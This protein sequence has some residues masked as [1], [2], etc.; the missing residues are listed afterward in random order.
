MN[1]I[2][3]FNE[4]TAQ[5][6]EFKAKY[7]DVVYNMEIPKE[8]KQARSDQR[9]IGSIVQ[10]LKKVKKT[11]KAPILAQMTNIDTTSKLLEEN[12]RIVQAKI[13]TQ[14]T[15]HDTRI[16][17]HKAMLQK[18]LD[19]ITSYANTALHINTSDDLF[20]LATKLA[21]TIID[22]SYEY[23]EE[24]AKTA[25]TAILND[26][27]KKHTELL[28]AEKLAEEVAVLRAKE[29]ERAKAAHEAAIAK[30]AAQQATA[31][32]E[33]LAQ[34]KLD[35]AAK[36]AENIRLANEQA[37]VTARLEKEAIENKLALAKIAAKED[38]DK[39]VAAEVLRIAEE[40]AKR[41]QEEEIV[42]NRLRAKAANKE[43]M[44]NVQKQIIKDLRQF[45]RLD[46]EQATYVLDALVAK[47]ITCVKIHY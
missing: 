3:E 32:A 11:L 13:K 44:Q 37:L 38:A 1:E 41:V 33:R 20:N 46:D 8:N 28:T 15:E 5:L 2:I 23:V 21:N 18:K 10:K 16:A 47:C 4:F 14:I 6:Q 34:I 27:K 19:N 31:E 30:Q 29:E 42:A 26:M 7:D 35:T 24:D 12:F 9:A 17:E 45:C 43:H 22:D 36:E 39:A 40:T 25:K